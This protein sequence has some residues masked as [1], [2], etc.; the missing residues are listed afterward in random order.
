[1]ESLKRL[2][3]SF[4]RVL[5]PGAVLALGVAACSDS[6][7]APVDPEPEPVGAEVFLRGTD[8]RLAYVHGDHWHGRIELEVGQEIE[9]DVRFLDEDDQVIALG[10]EYTVRGEIAPGHPAGL[11][12]VESHGDHLDIEAL[13]PGETRIVLH[14]WHDGHADW[15]TPALRVVVSEPAPEPVGAEVFLRGTDQR[16]AYVHGDHWHGRIELEVGQEIEVDVRFLDE[17]DQVIAL[18]G[19][20]TV[21]G[22]IAEGHPQG[23]VSVES[24]GD[25]L[26]IE[27]LAAGETR[28]VLHFWHDDHADW[29]TPALRVVVSEPA[30][31]PVGA[32]VYLRGT[33][34]RL[35]YVHGDH[36]H[37]RIELEVGQEIEVD[38]RFLD[39]DDQVI[40][41][42]GEYTVRAEIAEGHPDG[43]I[44]VEGHGD[45]L[46]IEALAA[47]ET[48]IVLHFW[49][50]DHADWSTPGLRVVVTD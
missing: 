16:L 38:V 40:A 4:R 18:G 30:P 45:H 2:F 44:E 3:P 47:G 27:A 32:E 48:R 25:H 20:Y 34:E 26:D 29:T 19:E 10:G 37:G 36:W 46:D 35:A 24:H 15:S 31:E 6:P 8:Q 42:G 28:I 1:M 9:V 43:I 21:R 7:L 33:D 50:D 12:S 13:S 23:L 17:D 39:E 5:L 22:E 14:F 41:L 11:V 49:H